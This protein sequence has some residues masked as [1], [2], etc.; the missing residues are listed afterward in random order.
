M[1][2]F[3]GYMYVLL[4]Y[5][6]KFFYVC[7]YVTI[8]VCMYVGVYVCAYLREHLCVCMHVTYAALKK[9]FACGF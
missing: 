8:S 9:D 6:C 1:F 5:D 7:I 2:V 4:S 3:V